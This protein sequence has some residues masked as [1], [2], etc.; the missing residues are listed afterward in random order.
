MLIE[1]PE[2]VLQGM[3]YTTAVLKEVAKYHLITSLHTLTKCLDF[4][5]ARD[6][7]WC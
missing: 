3:V 7:L 1:Q 6:C 5:N 4:E 2:T